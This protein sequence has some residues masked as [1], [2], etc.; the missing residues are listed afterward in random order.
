M[1]A[2]WLLLL[3]L[4]TSCGKEDPP[5][6]SQG[7]TYWQ[8]IAPLYYENCVACHQEGGIAPF[9]LDRYADAKTWALPAK[10]AVEAR[11]MPPWL[12]TADGSCGEFHE[13]RWL[14]DAAIEKISRWAAGGASEGTTRTD[15]QVP[16]RPGI[17]GAKSFHTPRFVPEIQGGA[18]AE[19]DDYRCFLIDPELTEDQFITGYEVVPGDPAIVHH[20]LAMPVDPD[21][22]IEPGLTNRQIMTMLDQESP[23]RDGWPC[24][25]L[26]GDRVAVDGVPVTWAPGMGAVEYP[27]ETGVYLPKNRL[28]VLQVHYN[29]SDPQHRGR[30]DSTELQ[31]RLASQVQRMGFFVLPDLFLNTLFTGEP[32]ALPPGEEAVDY[33][34]TANFDEDLAA[35]GV[36][37]VEVY[38]VMPHMHERGR[39]LKMEIGRDNNMSCAAAVERWDFGWQFF[40]FYEQPFEISTGTEVRVTC[41]FDTRGRTDPVLPGWGTQNEMCLTALYVVLPAGPLP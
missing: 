33:T 26:A 11:T 15:L 20:V 38:G 35:L 16:N 6:T 29:L 2:R 37:H 9:R 23:D 39:K 41:T 7:L 34:W 3:L 17:S 10:Q 40:Y 8:D 12:V 21:Q 31:L 1:K 13:S 22:V 36:D 24:F 5:A 32:A 18:F 19:F 14:D 4:S 30:E 27:A 28:L 25:G